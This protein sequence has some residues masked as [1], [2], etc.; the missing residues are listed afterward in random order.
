MGPSLH[1]PHPRAPSANPAIW[2]P[3]SAFSFQYWCCKVKTSKH[4]HQSSPRKQPETPKECAVEAILH[5]CVYV[6]SVFVS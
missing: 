4:F 6:N 1:R 2:G 3:A 5:L